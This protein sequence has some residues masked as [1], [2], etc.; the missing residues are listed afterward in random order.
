MVA[1]MLPGTEWPQ[2]QVGDGTALQGRGTWARNIATSSVRKSLRPVTV[3]LSIAQGFAARHP[4]GTGTGWNLTA[5]NPQ[6][7]SCQCYRPG[8]RNPCPALACQ[9]LP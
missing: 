6:E 2:E 7:G 4:K 3:L 8:T 1:G 9:L 5:H